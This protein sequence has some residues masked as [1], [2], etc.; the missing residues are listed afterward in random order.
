[1]IDDV[2]LESVKLSWSKPKEDGGD[3]IQ[4]YVIEAKEKGSTKWKP[5]NNEKHPCKGTKFTG[6]FSNKKYPVRQDRKHNGS[7][8]GLLLKYIAQITYHKETNFVAET[9][10][11]ILNK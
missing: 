9:L 7:R 11:V 3:K 2:D 4:G 1:M 10:F 8:L 6:K 5:L